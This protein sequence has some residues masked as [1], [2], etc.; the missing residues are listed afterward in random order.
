MS[1]ALLTS[2][3][4]IAL[5]IISICGM[6]DKK[7]ALKSVGWAAGGMKVNG[8][9]CNMYFGL[10]GIYVENEVVGMAYPTG[11]YE[12]GGRNSDSC[13]VFSSIAMDDGDLCGGCG[14]ISVDLVSSVITSLITMLPT[15]FTDI[16]RMYRQFDVN[17][18][19]GFQTILALITIILSMQSFWQYKFSCFD[20]FKDGDF[21]AEYNGTSL[22]ITDAEW[23][24]GWG[25][26]CI[27]FCFIGS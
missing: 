27:M 19:K 5:I 23:K 20:N 6:S 21:T 11:Y 26:R 3:T 13:T 25:F 14:D 8:Y 17:C 4:S 15:V 7:S 22:I 1:F 10:N 2:L 24:G 9:E 12:F 18:Q 16:L